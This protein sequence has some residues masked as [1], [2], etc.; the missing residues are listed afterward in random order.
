MRVEEEREL[1]GKIVDVLAGLAGGVDV[2]DAVGEGEGHLLGSR[3]PRLADVVSRDRDG[4]PPRHALAAKGEGVGDESHGRFRRKDVGPAGD[5]L[6]QDVVLHGTGEFLGRH[7]LALGHRDIEAEQ[8]G[9][10]RVDGHRGRRAIEG[11]PVEQLLHVL[12]ARDGDADLARL[13]PRHFVVGV[14]AHLSRQ[15]ER[16]AEAALPLLEEVAEAPVGLGRGSEARVLAHGPQAPAVAGGLNA[17]CVGELPRE[18]EIA[19]VVEIRDVGGGG[20]PLHGSAARAG[21]QDGPLGRAGERGF[22]RALLPGSTRVLDALAS[23]RGEIGRC[24]SGMFPCFLGGF[25]SRLVASTSR[26]WT[27]LRR[28]SRG[29][30][31]SST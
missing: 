26:A 9:G 4:V 12:D 2:G 30:M 24:H 18:S 13:A 16:H 22:E 27:S 3:A 20:E 1:R 17:A 29:S 6:L 21:E 25:W 10:G 31:T 15:V 23:V 8:D 28:V 7:A 5:V 14:V 19:Q 11:D